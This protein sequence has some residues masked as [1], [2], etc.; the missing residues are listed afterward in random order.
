MSSFPLSLSSLSNNA[1]ERLARLD[2]VGG[3][4]RARLLSPVPEVAS[5]P[6]LPGSPSRLSGSSAATLPAGGS[7][8]LGFGVPAGSEVG[9]SG[10]FLLS[11]GGVSGG[12]T[13]F[14]VTPELLD[15]LCCGAV[16]GG[17]KFCTLGSRSC[18]FTTHQRKAEVFP[19]HIYVSA[20]RNS[21][22]TFHHV[23]TAALATDQLSTLLQEQHSKE[24]WVRLLLGLNQGL[25][26]EKDTWNPP[27]RA[28]A[29]VLEA[30]TPARKKKSRYELR[31]QPAAGLSPGQ[32]Q[33][34][35]SLQESFDEEPVILSSEDSGDV[36]E[37][38][39]LRMV[40]T[41]WDVLVNLVNKLGASLRALRDTVGD[42]MFEMED[43]I[44]SVDACLGR[45][46]TRSDLDDFASAWDGIAFLSSEV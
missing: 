45:Q 5:G 23:P 29:S 15:T 31:V 25:M 10:E 43:K 30:A 39:K 34:S 35:A 7:L 4:L 27:A 22:F 13:A 32:G 3:A 24:E 41:Q 6:G 17:V 12:L 21:A 16:A 14:V 20:G 26:K 18:S 2:S 46:P 40:A 37:E 28:M 19:G 8:G 11:G 36:P 38:A 33:V 44:L 1:K 42:D 9:V